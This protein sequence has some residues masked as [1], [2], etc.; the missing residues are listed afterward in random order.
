M[1][2][3]HCSLLV[4][5]MIL[6]RCAAIAIAFCGTVSPAV[7]FASPTTIVA[8]STAEDFF[9]D[10]ISKVEQRDY[11][12]A[13][14]A[15]SRAIEADPEFTIAYYNRANLYYAIEEYEA[16]LED[17]DRA[18][19]LEPEYVSAYINR[20]NLRSLL[21]D[22]EGSIA[23][24]NEALRIANENDSIAVDPQVYYNRA[25]SY[26]DLRD[27]DSAIDDYTQTI[28]LDDSFIP[29]Y[30]NRSLAYLNRGL[31]LS[32]NDRRDS[33]ENN[34]EAAIADATHVIEIVPEAAEAYGNRGLANAYLG[35]T[36]AAISD[37]EIA[38]EL[39]ESSGR[40]DAA[41]E[42]IEWIDRLQ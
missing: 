11:R 21:G 23:D 14:A 19:E 31:V 16:A 41:R 26:A 6:I 28:A 1:F 15:F 40:L 4:E 22:I 42:V 3:A 29:A 18:L 5:L 35:N 24:Y 2:I 27:W 39:F 13:I 32:Q 33:A 30:L 36:E 34:Y 8:Q 12:G 9:R 25:L 10:G 7:A 37:L 20:G 38:A 17:Y